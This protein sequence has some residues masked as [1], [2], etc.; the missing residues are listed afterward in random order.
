LAF[1][2]YLAEINYFD[3]QV[4]EALELL[5]KHGHAENTVFI[6]ASEQGNSFPFAKWSCYNAGLG[7]AL[8]VHWPGVVS[9]GTTS[10][11]IVE[12]TDLLPTFIDIA[13]GDSVEYLDG[14]SFLPILKGEKTIHKSYTYG[15][16]TTRGINQGAEYYP[17]RSVSDGTYRLVLNL[18]P[19]MKFRNVVT[20]N[21]DFFKT[22]VNSAN[23]EYRQLAE[24]YMSRPAI[25]FFN[26]VNDPYNIDNLAEGP[27]Y[28]EKIN[29]LRD[30][31]YRWMEYCGDKGIETELKADQ[32]GRGQQG[33]QEVIVYTELHDALNEGNIEVSTEG[34]YSFYTE[35]DCKIYV[36]DKLVIDR[37]ENSSVP[38]VLV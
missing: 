34:F 21:S 1:R 23:P 14:W 25:E 10:D 11:A 22:W 26:D 13:G 9:P 4:K 32:F 18:S 36:N 33:M 27:Q 29:E 28:T 15:M 17:I 3:G 12:Y 5:G 35:N 6:F 7:S 8:I 30:E 19:E 31:L 20:E 16:Q 2:D 24:R 38:Y 37:I